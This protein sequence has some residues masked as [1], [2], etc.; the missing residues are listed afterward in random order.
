MRGQTNG[1][2][3]QYD[4]KNNGATRSSSGSA[5][6]PDPNTSLQDG[7][8]AN[9]KRPLNSNYKNILIPQPVLRKYLDLKPGQV[10]MSVPSANIVSGEPTPRD[11]LEVRGPKAS[12]RESAASQ[13]KDKSKTNKTKIQIR[14]ALLQ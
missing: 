12:E 6:K 2:Q 3:S 10:Y 13:Q 11:L 8:H 9:F 4:K 7:Q 14:K 1:R 5:R